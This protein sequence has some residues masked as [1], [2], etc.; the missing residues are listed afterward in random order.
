MV[1]K[2]LS[3]Q[4]SAMILRCMCH[5]TL[6]G[7]I[8]EGMKILKSAIVQHVIGYRKNKTITLQISKFPLHSK[9]L[10]WTLGPTVV[11]I[12]NWP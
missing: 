9:P 11:C 1:Y 10:D 3:N 6:P 8:L 5:Q 7:K 4:Y 2:Y 12:A